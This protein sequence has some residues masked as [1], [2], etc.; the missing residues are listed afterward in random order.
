MNT[1]ALILVLI[2]NGMA[3]IYDIDDRSAAQSGDKNSG[4]I[5]AQIP[6]SKFDFEKLSYKNKVTLKERHN[7]CDGERNELKHS[8][9]ECS[10][11]LVDQDLIMTAGHC[12]DLNGKSI[13]KNCEDHHWVLD[14]YQTDTFKIENVYSCKSI[15]IIRADYEENSDY[16]LIRLDRKINRESFKLSLKI[17]SIDEG[18]TSLGFPHGMTMVDSGKGLF[19]GR[20]HNR[21]YLYSL[22]LF[23]GNSGSPIINTN[24]NEVV[25][26]HI[27]GPAYSL[28]EDFENKCF[29]ENTC[30][31]Y[32]ESC[33]G[34]TG[35]P[36]SKMSS[37]IFKRYFKN[38][39]SK[40]Y[41]D[42]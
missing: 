24:T 18:M 39:N 42:Y 5:L 2:L 37:Y 25:A 11:F 8:L 36:I 13:Y 41:L 7:L 17:P 30:E 16:A 40:L 23:G 21:H 29:K 10:A 20:D 15:E 31:N 19:K 1:L 14:H 27:K 38:E 34:S 26:V 9:V 33:R 3:M 4:K 28:Y 12:L 6:K 32:D 35:F 22:D